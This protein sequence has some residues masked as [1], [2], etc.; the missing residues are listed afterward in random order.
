VAFDLGVAPLAHPRPAG[1]QI[2]AQDRAHGLGGAGLGLGLVALRIASEA[3]LS[4]KIARRLAGLRQRQRAS[5]AER[6]A[7]MLPTDL[8]LENE[9]SAAACPDDICPFSRELQGW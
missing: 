4:V 8:E 2:R 5:T 7:P 3:D 9:G 6:D 1:W